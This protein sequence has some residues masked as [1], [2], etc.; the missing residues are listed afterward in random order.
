MPL[1][2]FHAWILKFSTIF[3]N[4][5]N[6]KWLLDLSEMFCVRGESCAHCYCVSLYHSTDTVCDWGA[7][8]L[9][10][11]LMQMSACN[12][13]LQSDRVTMGLCD[14]ELEEHPVPGDQT[15]AW[16]TLNCSWDY[17]F[18]ATSMQVCW[19]REGL[20]AGLNNLERT[21][22]SVTLCIL[23]KLNLKQLLLQINKSQDFILIGSSK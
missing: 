6:R 5:R 14:Q 22:M 17:L 16:L 12:N 7:S 8:L 20:W 18:F 23:R 3:F 15:V 9:L 11:A 19:H 4:V 10:Q 1:K 2:L 21:L 13:Y